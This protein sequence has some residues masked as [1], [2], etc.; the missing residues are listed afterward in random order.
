MEMSVECPTTFTLTPPSTQRIQ[1]DDNFLF[2]ALCCAIMGMQTGHKALC[3]I[4][5]DHLCQGT[6][7]TGID[8]KDYLASLQMQQDKKYGTVIE[9]MVA[10]QVLDIHFVYHKYGKTH[11]WLH[12]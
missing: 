5:C 12:Y 9:L 6:T 3:Q 2:R 7:Y 1:G 10:A 11:K 8:G 4:I